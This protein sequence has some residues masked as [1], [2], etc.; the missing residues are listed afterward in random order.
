MLSSQFQLS[1]SHT[2]KSEF[3]RCDLNEFSLICNFKLSIT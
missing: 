3:I 2:G 1:Y